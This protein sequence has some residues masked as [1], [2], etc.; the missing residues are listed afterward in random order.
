MCYSVC[1]LVAIF[2]KNGIDEH[3]TRTK[4]LLCDFNMYLLLHFIP[5]FSLSLFLSPF[6]CVFPSLTIERIRAWIVI[7]SKLTKT[8]QNEWANLSIAFYICSIASH[9]NTGSSK[10]TKP[11]RKQ[12]RRQQWLFH[13]WCFYQTTTDAHT[14]AGKINFNMLRAYTWIVYRHCLQTQENIQIAQSAC[15]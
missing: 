5:T 6:L 9:S 4:C 2:L 15:N 10:R 3:S 14:T 7:S 12:Y 13:K 8:G 11:N 1:D